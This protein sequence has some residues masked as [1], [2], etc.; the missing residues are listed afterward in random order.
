MTYVGG[1]IGI[2]SREKYVVPDSS[3][4]VL[5][6]DTVFTDGILVLNRN[7]DRVWSWIVTDVQ[8]PMLDSDIKNKQ[9]DWGHANSL[10]VDSDGHYLVSW[11]KPKL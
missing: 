5:G 2:L 4:V 1:N 3:K 10:D 9:K 6:I 7:G 11:R 8:N